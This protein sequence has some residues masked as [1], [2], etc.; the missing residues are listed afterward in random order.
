M[1]RDTTSRSRPGSRRERAGQS[2]RARTRRRPRRRRRCRRSPRRPR[3]SSPAD[4]PVPVGLLGE[5]KNT[6]S[7]CVASIPR[8]A[9]SGRDFEFGIALGGHPG[10]AGARRD[11]RSASNRWAGSRARCG[12]GPPNAWSRCCSTSLEPFAAQMFS[13]AD[14]VAEVAG[15]A[16]AQRGELAVRIAVDRR[17]RPRPVPPRCRWRPTPESGCVFSL[18]LSAIRTGFCGAP[19][20]VRPLRSSRMGRSEREITLPIVLPR[21]ARSAL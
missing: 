20:G 7:G 18:T 12:P 8:T 21:P 6:T 16:L 15:E 11:D 19:Y 10:G 17:A 4:T 3:R 9:V 14:P 5:Q 13:A 1:V 2:C